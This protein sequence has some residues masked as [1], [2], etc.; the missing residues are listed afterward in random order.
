MNELQC[1]P[2]LL[3]QRSDSTSVLRPAGVCNKSEVYLHLN[4]VLS[5][6]PAYIFRPDDVNLHFVLSP[7]PE[8]TLL[9]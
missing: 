6:I 1:I 3:K 4:I 5:G 7:V 2:V 8:Y 9:W